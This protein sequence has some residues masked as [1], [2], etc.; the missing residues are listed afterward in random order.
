MQFRN[1]VYE[2]KKHWV[3]KVND[4]YEVYR[5]GVTHSTRCS[6]IDTTGNKGL[7]KAIKEC[8][9]RDNELFLNPIKK[10]GVL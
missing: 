6:Q 4:G 7:E 10:V 3:L 1:I 9:K 5:L 2:G 8:N